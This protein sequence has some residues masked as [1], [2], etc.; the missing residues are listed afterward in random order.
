M[1]PWM[2]VKVRIYPS[3]GVRDGKEKK[4]KILRK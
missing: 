3:L 4:E 1:K 2:D